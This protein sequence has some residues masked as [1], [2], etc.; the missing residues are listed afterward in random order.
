MRID[1]P[2]LNENLRQRMNQAQPASV[3]KSAF[4][5]MTGSAPED[6]V[7]PLQ[8]QFFANYHTFG[9]WGSRFAALAN[10][11]MSLP[12]ARSLHGERLRRGSPA[13]VAAV[14]GEDLGAIVS[15]RAGVRSPAT[16]QP[17]LVMLADMFT[18]YGSPERG[19]AAV[20]VLRA[21]GLDVV[22]SPAMPD[23]RAAMS[24]GMIETARRQAAP[25]LPMLRRYLTREERS[26]LLEPSVLA[27]LRFDFKH[28]LD[29]D[30]HGSAARAEQLRAAANGV[31]DRAGATISIWRKIFPGQKSQHGTR[32]FYHSHCQQR[33][34]TPRRKPSTCCARPGSTS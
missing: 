10:A 28:L 22:L 1:I 7:A 33:P 12:G 13:R 6:R 32:L 30:E 3:A 29:D 26:S 19:M 2:W 9:K 14:P 15:R 23:G 25:W 5:A 24:Q 20:R 31:A 11:S 34:A 27:M 4:G 21:I 18:N 16:V 17:G 8:K